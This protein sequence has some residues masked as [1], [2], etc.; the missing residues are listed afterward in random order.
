MKDELR[1]S[2]KATGRRPSNTTRI[3]DLETQLAD[4]RAQIE[5]LRTAVGALDYLLYPEVMR[6]LRNMSGGPVCK[7]SDDSWRLNGFYAVETGQDGTPFR[8]SNPDLECS[9]LFFLI[10]GETYRGRVS[11]Q[12]PG[13]HGPGAISVAI[14][15]QNLQSHATP[16]HIE[17]TFVARRMGWH[18]VTLAP[19][20][21]YALPKGNPD[22]RKL[23]LVFRSAEML[24]L[25][26]I[27][28]A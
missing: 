8:W 25:P 15:G 26:E 18:A 9:V 20:T 24:P 16:E 23:G 17:F 28:N 1:S 2:G 10:E 19:T 11:A 27:A 14:E 5:A 12:V 13:K 6:V 7:A 4:A 22:Y 21:P 3:S